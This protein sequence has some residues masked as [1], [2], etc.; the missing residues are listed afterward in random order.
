MK[1]NKMSFLSVLV[2]ILAVGCAST[3][4]DEEDYSNRLGKVELGM[5]KSEFMQIFPGV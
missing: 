5:S 4:L 2:T 3:K 1:L